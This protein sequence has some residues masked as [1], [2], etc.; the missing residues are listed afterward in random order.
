M[1]VDVSHVSDKTFFDTLAVT[2][3]PVIV[4]HSSMRAL[5]CSAECVG[6]DVVGFARN[7][8]C[9]VSAS[10]SVRVLSIRNDA[11]RRWNPP[12]RRRPPPAAD[13]EGA[14]RLRSGGRAD[15]I[16]HRVKVAATVEDVADHMDHAV[17]VA[18]IDHVGIGSDF[19]GVSG[20]PNELDDVS[21]MPA[22]NRSVA[23][24]R[25]H[26]AGCEEDPGRELSA[27]DSR[28]DGQV[29]GYEKKE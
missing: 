22:L 24:T 12:I 26:R 3:K 18:G 28:G 19:D 23:G 8:G 27:S 21:K 20:R 14:G 1:L 25:L 6:R 10:I 15:A 16:G 11:G 17:K 29:D 13:R 4:S 7:D 9:I 5:G 2:T